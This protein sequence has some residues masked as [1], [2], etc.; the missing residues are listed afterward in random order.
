MNQ[1]IATINAVVA[2][3]SFTQVSADVTE[4]PIAPNLQN[5]KQVIIIG[6]AP[7]GSPKT[8]QLVGSDST[9]MIII[10]FNLTG[11][12]AQ[13]FPSNFIMND[14]RWNT[15]TKVWT[16]QDAGNYKAVGIYDGVNWWIDITGATYI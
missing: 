4:S 8:W 2:N 11:L 3:F 9:L 16:P 5:T 10:L 1:I 6:S 13:T 14:V 12:Y 7:I 15:I